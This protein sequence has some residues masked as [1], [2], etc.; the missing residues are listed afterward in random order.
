[1]TI[2][3]PTPTRPSTY[4]YRDR[5]LEYHVITPIVLQALDKTYPTMI[6]SS[7]LYDTV[8]SVSLE[9]STVGAY[10]S[11]LCEHDRVGLVQNLAQLIKSSTLTD[12][13]NDDSE[14]MF[15]TMLDMTQTLDQLMSHGEWLELAKHASDT[16]WDGTTQYD[17]TLNHY[18][19]PATILTMYQF[20]NDSVDFDD[21]WS[22]L[23]FDYDYEVRQGNAGPYDAPKPEWYDELRSR[24]MDDLWSIERDRKRREKQK[25]YESQCDHDLPFDAEDLDGESDVMRA[26]DWASED[27]DDLDINPESP[28]NGGH[29]YDEDSDPLSSVR[30]EIAGEAWSKTHVRILPCDH[31]EGEVDSKPSWDLGN[32]EIGADA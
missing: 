3:M 32:G 21:A 15:N 24:S 12:R 31:P 30:R 13:F 10:W 22:D 5:I 1:M 2:P 9:D 29:P 28:V 23:Q 25:A 18:G 20:F 4:I 26:Q 27:P 17:R 11:G 14:D 7:K 19:L 6:P 16:K 8:K